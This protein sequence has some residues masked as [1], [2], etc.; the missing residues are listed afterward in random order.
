MLG[1]RS[2]RRGCLIDIL[3]GLESLSFELWR[4]AMEVNDVE[5]IEHGKVFEVLMSN[6]LGFSLIVLSTVG[7][8]R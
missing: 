5:F 1:G 6:G 2:H 7:L 3:N 4:Y 8:P